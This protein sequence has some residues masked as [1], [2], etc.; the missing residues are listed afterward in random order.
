MNQSKHSLNIEQVYLDTLD[1]LKG[2]KESRRSI[3]A[4]ID[5]SQG[6]L[7]KLAHGEWDDPGILKI[8]RLHNYLLGNGSKQVDVT[9]DKE[10]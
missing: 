5:V 2:A 9:P 4:R 6:W 1:M 3:A 8:G 10:A 7:N